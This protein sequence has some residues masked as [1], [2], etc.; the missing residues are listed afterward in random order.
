[1][2][3][4]DDIWWM[5]LA[6]K[7]AQST[8]LQTSPNPP[9]GAVITKDSNL[10]SLGAHLKHGSEHAEVNATKQ[11][12]ETE[13]NGSTLYITLE[14]CCHYG[15]TNP[16]TQVIIKYK[17]TRVVV[18]VIDQNPL[19]HCK[20]IE[21]LRNAGITVDIGICEEEAAKLYE[22]FFYYIKYN[23]PYI[24][25]KAAVSLDGKLC[26]TIKESKWITN[27][28]ARMDSHLYRAQHNAILVGINTIIMDDPLLTNRGDH[29]HK[30]PTI[31]VLDNELKISMQAKILQNNKVIIF[32]SKDNYKTKELSKRSTVEI[33]N[34]PREISLHN[35]LTIL[36][37]K[38]HIISILVE[39]GVKIYHSFIKNNLFNRLIMYMSPMILGGSY[40]FFSSN[41]YIKLDEPQNLQINSV[42]MI[43]GNMKMVV[44]RN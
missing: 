5:S 33:I 13:L 9:V 18:A 36:A 15:H 12:N 3:I 37:E 30:Q 8:A 34:V 38:Y 24:T 10:I 28:T 1:M 7:I 41:Q 39:G 35:I 27:E 43:D 31:V 6:I 11:I 29:Q 32:T 20:G 14:P 17:I 40:Q 16:C 23:I 2:N 26:N 42:E 44:V 21:Q 19:V 25:L 22:H 4:R